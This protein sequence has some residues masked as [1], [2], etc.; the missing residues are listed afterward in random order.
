MYINTQWL[1][2]LL[3]RTKE[4]SDKTKAMLLDAA[5][6]VFSRQGYATTTLQDIA[7][8]AGMTRGAV[9]HH[10]DGKGD[11]LNQLCLD[12][13]GRLKMDDDAK[14]QDDKLTTLKKMIMSYFKIL[15]EDPQFADLQYLLTFKTELSDELLGGM[16]EKVRS[17]R[18][19]IDHYASLF[20]ELTS[21]LEAHKAATMV[22]AFQSGL[23]NLWLM[24]RTSVDLS[25]DV[26]RMV[27]VLLSKI[28]NK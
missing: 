25:R 21:K 20:L 11:I 9:Y 15:N 6:R 8:E 24:D 27:D 13:Y 22:V 17:T 23:T 1:R 7:K 14:P 26:P 5:Q 12:R 3:K 18:A 16:E 19:L 10:F 2:L 28:M 4:D